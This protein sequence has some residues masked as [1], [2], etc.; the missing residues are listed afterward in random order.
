MTTTCPECGA[1]LE[2]ETTCQSIFD[3]FL[4]LEFTDPAFGEVHML[5]VACYM[6]QHN[7]YSD[8]GL[9]WISKTLRE[10]LT[11]AKIEQIRRQ[12]N[13]EVS[14]GSR[15]WKITRQPND[16][17]LPPIAWSTTIADVAARSRGADGL[18]DAERYCSQVREWAK[19]TL[20][21]MQPLIRHI[22]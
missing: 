20:E 16:P 2:S 21:E 12:A 22:S 9:V 19:S 15:S 14:Q 3:D 8:P 5:T 4:V 18:P 10:N 1:R 13:Q 17:P 11:G 6:I 7:R